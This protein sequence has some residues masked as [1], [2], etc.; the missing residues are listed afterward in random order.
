V[1]SF[2]RTMLDFR[3]ERLADHEWAG[4][5]VAAVHITGSAFLWHQVPPVSTCRGCHGRVL[6][7]QRCCCLAK[8]RRLL[9]SQLLSLA[10]VLVTKALLQTFQ[11]SLARFAASERAT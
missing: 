1:V 10:L 7:P 3:I 8:W 9:G 2:K 4:R 11:H 5:G 6:H